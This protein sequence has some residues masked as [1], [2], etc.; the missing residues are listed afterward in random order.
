MTNLNETISENFKRLRGERSLS[1]DDVAKLTGVS[2]SMLGQIERGEVNPTIT[3]VWKIANGLKISFTALVSRPES[4]VEVV[5]KDD[6]Q[7]FKEGG[8]V[9]TSP[10]FPFEEKRGF[11]MYLFEVEPG[12]IRSAEAHLPKSQEFVT[13]FSGVL[14][15]SIDGTSYK[16]K[17]GDSIRFNADV[18]H[19][20]WNA[21][22]KLVQASM[23]ISYAP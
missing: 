23:V 13:V 10:V 16:L 14:L 8:T 11:E 12:G 1:L 22:D 15:I 18:P 21:G 4:D 17:K 3:T 6:L 7:P 20:Y 5:C 2:K 19:T 9:R